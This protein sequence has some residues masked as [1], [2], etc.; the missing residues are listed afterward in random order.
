MDPPCHAPAHPC[1][2]PM[3]HVPGH[4]PHVPS[5][6]RAPRASATHPQPLLTCPDTLPHVPSPICILLM[7]LPIWTKCVILMR[8]VSVRCTAVQMHKLL[9]INMWAGQLA[10]KG[11]NWI[12]KHTIKQDRPAGAIHF[13]TYCSHVLRTCIRHSRKW[14]WVPIITQSVDGVLCVLPNA[15]SLLPPS[16]HKHRAVGCQSPI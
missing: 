13:H 8:L 2:M 15:T 4:F 11:M 3:P 10:C 12:L 5:P 9:M 16:L 1:L 14:L 6:V 7:E